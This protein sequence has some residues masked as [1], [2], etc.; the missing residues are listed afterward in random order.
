MSAGTIIADM[1]L[2]RARLITGDNLELQSSCFT[3]TLYHTERT[4]TCL[5]SVSRISC[6]RQ[7][8]WR[9]CHVEI[10][11]LFVGQTGVGKS[12]LINMIRGVPDNTDGA[13]KVSNDARPCTTQTTSYSTSLETGFPCRIWD[14]RGLDE[15]ADTHDRGWMTKIVDR[16]RQLAFQQARELKETLRDRTRLAIPILM[17]CIDATKIDVPIHW[18]QFRRVYVEYCERKAIPVVVITRMA[19]NATGWEDRCSNQL[20][21]LDL[22]EGSNTV[23]VPL[24]RV[25]KYK[26]RS[27]TE[28][29]EDSQ[30]LKDLISRLTS[31]RNVN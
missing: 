5:H 19:P 30:A 29:T 11:V 18:Q 12:T 10:D 8:E 17:W 25:R 31:S 1:D 28:Y 23:D 6:F 21:R 20:Q 4:N 3:A 13:A 14:T 9:R 15:A 24:L 26:D 7:P 27:S 2:P 22:G 16:I